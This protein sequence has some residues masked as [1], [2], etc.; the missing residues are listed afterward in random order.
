MYMCNIILLFRSVGLPGSE[1]AHVFGSNHQNSRPHSPE[2]V[3][4]LLALHGGF[5][6]AEIGCRRRNWIGHSGDQTREA[7]AT[8]KRPQRRTTNRRRRLTQNRRAS[9][10]FKNNQSCK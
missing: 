8:E 1:S 4:A 6:A 9:L 5:D 7:T 10:P 3:P 2:T